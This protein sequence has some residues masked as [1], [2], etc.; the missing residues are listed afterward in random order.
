VESG[1]SIRAL[2]FD[3]FGTVVDWRSSVIREG[4]ALG[5]AR[6]VQVDWG[7][8]ADDWR[9]EGYTEAIQRIGR[10]ELSWL[11]VDALHR[12]E[13]DRLLERHGIGGL[14]E[15]EIAQFNRV[16]HRLAPWPDAVAGLTR[17]RRSFIVSPLSNGDFA[18]LTNLARAAG[19]PWDCIISAELFHCFKPD[20]RVY[21]GAAA[22]LDLPPEAVMLVA[23]HPGDL[24]GARAAGLRT[25]LVLRPL[26]HGPGHPT[27]PV[28]T[29]AFD[30]VAG[31]FLDLADQ[32]GA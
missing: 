18:L 13:L 1:S 29:A 21:Q 5:R 4:E 2:V 28:D 17:L 8:F 23:A 6:G 25:A 12:Q 16:W 27:P 31:D 10:G 11:R 19:L 9:R 3:V 32:L 26:E 24:H 20:P 7:R 14:S 15:A 22:L 30:L